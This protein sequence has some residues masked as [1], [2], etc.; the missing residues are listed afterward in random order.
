MELHF[1][2]D[3]Q[4]QIDRLVN[5]T[6]W[7]ADKLIEDAMAGYVAE[8]AQTRQMLTDRYNDMKSGRVTAIDGESFFESLRIREDELLNQ[9]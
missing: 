5:E 2:P 1:T 6:G 7:P 9:E 8:L 4:A 3:L